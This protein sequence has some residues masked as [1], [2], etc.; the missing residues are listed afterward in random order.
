MVYPLADTGNA[1]PP[2]ITDP[3]RCLGDE[4]DR[5]GEI[6]AMIS[7]I[8]GEGRAVTGDSVALRRRI[9]VLERREREPCCHIPISGI[10]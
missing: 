2:K 7:S 10:W 9:E 5:F 6:S 1:I 3:I 4:S 8:F